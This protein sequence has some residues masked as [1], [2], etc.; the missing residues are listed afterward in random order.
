MEKV[1][2]KTYG[3]QMNVYDSERMMD[4]LAPLGYEPTEHPD[5]AQ[6]AIL[7]T[8]HIR[9]KASEKLYSDLGRLKPVKEEALER[10][11][12]YLIAVTGCTAQAEGGEVFRRAP[13]V[14]MVVG[15][16][17]YQDLPELLARAKRMAESREA[18]KKSG[19]GIL[20]V[21][22][23]EVPKFDHLPPIGQH[24]GPTAFV[25]IQEGCDKFCHF[26][27]VPYTRGAEYSRPAQ[28]VVNEVKQFLAKGVKEITLLGQNVNAYHGEGLSTPQEWT[29]GRLIRALAELDGLES[30]RYMTSH[31]RDVND[32]LIDAH[33]D[34]PQ[35]QPFL[36]LPIQSGSDRI[37]KAMNRRHTVAFYLDILERFRK[38]RPDIAFSSDF[39]VGY[40]GETDADF[41]ETLELVET[42]GYAQAYSFKYSPRPGTPA[43]ALEN[44]IPEE[45][46]ETRLAILQNVL[47]DKQ[48]AFNETMIGKTLH[49]LFERKGRH[50]G[51]ILGKSPYMQSVH[52]QGASTVLGQI[53]P[54]KIQ[55][56]AN[57]SLT[58]ELVM[59][60]NK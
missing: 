45:I 39:I 3:C 52:V 53:L 10:G 6:L 25:A 22:F 43:W 46:K 40:P 2:I 47:M 36:H 13:Y 57:N 29:L 8:C 58:G 15:P 33:R 28:A 11:E 59:S 19:V 31:P 44:Q 23:P 30:I 12:D 54:V 42:V 9:E 21:D 18:G 1:Y 17:S 32:D 50:Q 48:R 41:K 34:V 37:L 56:A 26:C 51:Q 14:D 49:I 7:N 35:L 27:C 60:H 4:L 24:A 16:Q 38:A 55:A 20:N 5:N